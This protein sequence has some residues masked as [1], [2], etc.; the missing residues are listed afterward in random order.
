MNCSELELQP[1]RA[2]VAVARAF[3]VSW[4]RALGLGECAEV[5]ELLV[6]ETVTNAV[7]HAR[8]PL[9]LR[10]SWNDE[11]IV[12]VEVTDAARA[13]LHA[14]VCRAEATTGLNRPGFD[15]DCDLSW[16][17]WRPVTGISCCGCDGASGFELGWGQHAK[18]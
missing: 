3:A 10:M 12:Q 15:G 13:A 4:A 8:T 14:R 5:V 7:V 6:S 16:V 1:H 18:C 2:N 9:R 17:R 11:G